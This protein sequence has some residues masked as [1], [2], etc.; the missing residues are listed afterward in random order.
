M[1][2][3]Y[4]KITEVS[5][6][7]FGFYGNEC[8]HDL[9]IYGRDRKKIGS[10]YGVDVVYQGTDYETVFDDLYSLCEQGDMDEVAEYLGVEC[11]PG[12]WLDEDGMIDTEKLPES[13]C[14]HLYDAYNETLLDYYL[15]D[16]FAD[17]MEENDLIPLNV[18]AERLTFGEIGHFLEMDLDKSLAYM[19]RKLGATFYPDWKDEEKGN[20][21]VELTK[22]IDKTLFA[23]L[24]RI[25]D[26]HLADADCV[27]AIVNIRFGGD[28][29]YES[30][31]AGIM[32]HA[33]ESIVCEILN[34]LRPMIASLK[35]IDWKF[36][37]ADAVTSI[38]R[39]EGFLYGD[40]DACLEDMYDEV[41]SRLVD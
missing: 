4:V 22:E 2:E 25:V 37:L 6:V 40:E 18:Y 38:G 32:N 41:Y 5:K 19:F 11:I 10:A 30:E 3:Y 29:D 16:D 17:V 39:E 34:S 14:E 36:A 24:K 28:Y 8:R 13:V 33:C 15:V 12:D 31:A 1:G 35:E 7:N 23:K 26:E 21:P 27:S 9:E 20:A